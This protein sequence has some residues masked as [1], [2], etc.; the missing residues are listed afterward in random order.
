MFNLSKV[1]NKKLIGT[2]YGNSSPY[3]ISFINSQLDWYSMP[4]LEKIVKANRTAVDKI[5]AI[6]ASYGQLRTDVN[7][8]IFIN[9]ID[10]DTRNG[11]FK[12]ILS[13]ELFKSSDMN[14]SILRVLGAYRV[15]GGDYRIIKVDK[16]TLKESNIEALRVIG[17]E[18]N[19]LKPTKYSDTVLVPAKNNVLI[20]DLI[21]QDTN[22]PKKD[23]V[24]SDFEKILNS[25]KVS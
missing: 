7:L 25:I 10:E 16:I 24:I 21:V 6:P 22:E 4:T 14:E 15:K 17:E 11:F 23:I 13:E 5:V 1:F 9:P 2:V 3:S 18:Q 8:L 12:N 20:F 19:N